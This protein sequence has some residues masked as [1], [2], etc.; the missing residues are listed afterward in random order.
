MFYTKRIS[1]GLLFSL[2]FFSN[3]I[4]L[5]QKNRYIKHNVCIGLV[6]LSKPCMGPFRMGKLCSVRLSVHYSVHTRILGPKSFW[7]FISTLLSMVDT[8]KMFTLKCQISYRTGSDT[9]YLGTFALD[10]EINIKLTYCKKVFFSL[11]IY[12]PES[13]QQFFRFPTFSLSPLLTYHF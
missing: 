8:K 1:E 2:W 12:L 11:S 3:V 5:E 9:F 4:W 6:Y 10:F 13:F 7:N